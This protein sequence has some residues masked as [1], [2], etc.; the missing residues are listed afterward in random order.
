STS[1][2]E[3]F[4]SDGVR[5]TTN[6]PF[7]VST[8]IQK[9]RTI[10]GDRFAVT[11]TGGNDS[12]S[13]R[14]NDGTAS[15]TVASGLA[16]GT[17]CD[18]TDILE[19]PDGR[20]LISYQIAAVQGIEL[21]SSTF[22]R[23]G[24]FFQNSTLLQNISSMALLANGNVLACSSTFNVCEQLAISGSVGVRVGSSAFIDDASRVRQPTDVVVV[25]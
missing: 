21:Y 12:V 23:I 15:T 1:S 13:I 11:Y 9:V 3:K 6:Y 16:C 5:V 24:T 4:D 8:T 19:L 2:I 22:V 10:S 20:F 25:P 7:T 17:N 14:N 18:P